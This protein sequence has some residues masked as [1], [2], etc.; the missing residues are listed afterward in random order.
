MLNVIQNMTHSIR[1]AFGDSSVTYGPSLP[2]RTPYMGLLEG[3]GA[4]G[5]GWTAVVTPII[6][7][8]KLLGFDYKIRSSVS[9]S[10]LKILCVAFVDDTDLFHSGNS[11]STSGTEVALQ[12]QSILDHWDN[13]I[14]ITGG[15]LEKSKSYWYLLDY[16][17]R[18]GKWTYKPINSVPGKIS[19][20]NDKT[21]AKEPIERLP[22]SSARKALG[23]S[24]C[25]TGNMAAEVA[26]LVKKTKTWAAS[27]QTR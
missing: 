6:N 5:T 24:T 13:L 8:M 9:R 14:Q 12:M 20:Y 15:A 7:A 25:P 10:L 26:Y 18:Q 2:P 21:Q 22:P 11:N 1:T 23:I 4:A 19:L 16:T 17:F 3:N 27:L